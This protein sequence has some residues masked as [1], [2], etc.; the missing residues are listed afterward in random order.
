MYN[1]TSKSVG[2]PRSFLI[3]LKKRRGFILKTKKDFVLLITFALFM[4]WLLNNFSI[5]TG[6]TSSFFGLLIPIILGSAF[7]FIVNVPM[8]KIEQGLS[9]FPKLNKFRRVL[10]MVLAFCLIFGMIGLILI[11]V[12]PDFISTINAFIKAAPKLL[13]KLNILLNAYKLDYP[14]LN[15]L[16]LDISWNTISAQAISWLQSFGKTFLTSALVL[17]S[18]TLG[19]VVNFFIALVFAIYVL[20]SKDTL[21]AQVKRLI[22]N[23]CPKKADSILY[24]SRKTATIFN[25]FILGATIEAC[26]LGGIVFITMLIFKMPFTLTISV[27]IGAFSLIPIF[28]AFIALAIGFVL[29]ASV[30]LVQALWFVI[31]ILVIQQLEGNLI[32]PRVVGNSVGLPGIW[33][34]VSVT[35][36]GAFFGLLGMLLMVPITSVIYTLTKEYIV[37]KETE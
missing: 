27:L 32:Y 24:V 22:V 5:F 20:T 36:G 26:I 19:G 18:G 23:L 10:A 16:T 3:I 15:M 21:K 35:L 37:K 17:L 6:L 2:N 14:Q 25:N 33:V 13:T 29:I 31:L 12:L 28:G 8:V 7:A 11:L 1:Y 9:R 4:N 34:F 30:N